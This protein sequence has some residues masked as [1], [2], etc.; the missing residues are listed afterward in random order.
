MLLYY[1]TT[2][3]NANDIKINGFSFSTFDKTICFTND[4]QK[5]FYH[6]GENG[7]VLK[8]KILDYF[9]LK[10]EREYLNENKNDIRE[11]K[12]IIMYSKLNSNK[13]CLV[14]I[15]DNEFIFFNKFGYKIYL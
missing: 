4:Y 8:V 7:E 11:I 6:S 13:N 5:A 1:G 9:P 3:E 12:T 14:N 10:L 15:H 2:K